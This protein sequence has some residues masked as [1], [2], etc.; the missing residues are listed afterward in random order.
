MEG[1]DT[2][3]GFQG[4]FQDLSALS[5]SSVFNIE[6]LREQLDA[7][8]DAFQKLLDRPRKSNTSRQ[9][10]LSGMHGLLSG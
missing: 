1:P 7:H 2:L 4:L 9:T 3:A 8:I 5:S 6:R 10:V